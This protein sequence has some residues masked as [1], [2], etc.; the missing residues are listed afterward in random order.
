MLFEYLWL[1]DL[2]GFIGSVWMVES[3]KVYLV[4]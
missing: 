1:G 3:F 2:V 4:V